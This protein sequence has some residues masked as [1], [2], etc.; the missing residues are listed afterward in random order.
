MLANLAHPLEASTQLFEDS[1]CSL[2]VRRFI[3]SIKRTAL[4]R[5]IDKVFAKP[6]DVDR[7]GIFDIDRD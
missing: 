1:G 6:L 5:R 3:S 2:L 7:I 4:L